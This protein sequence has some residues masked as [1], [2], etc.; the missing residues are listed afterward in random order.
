M[1]GLDKMQ[2][3]ELSKSS[4]GTLTISCSGLPEDCENLKSIQLGAFTFEL[5]SHANMNQVQHNLTFISKDSSYGYIKST[6]AA[7]Y[8]T[9]PQSLYDAY[10]KSIVPK[11][12]APDLGGG[13]AQ[14]RIRT[15]ID[16]WLNDVEGWTVGDIL[17][18]IYTGTIAVP[19]GLD[20]AVNEMQVNA[21]V[22]VVSVVRSL[23][24]SPGLQCSFNGINVHITFG[25]GGINSPGSDCWETGITKR[26]SEYK[27]TVIG[28][29][30]F[31]LNVSGGATI[32][33]A[34]S[35]D[36][37]SGVSTV[38]GGGA[39]GS[40][41]GVSNIGGG[42]DVQV[43]INKVGGLFGTHLEHTT[44]WSSTNFVEAMF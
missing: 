2:Y 18:N 40:G 12:L 26:E 8:K 39:G 19:G 25:G 23:I 43:F 32:A 33:D 6:E 34:S 11:E 22:P 5:I 38:F 7:V 15:C 37:F 9:I 24:P 14:V 21:G 30:S 3:A 13:G 29:N 17:N 35:T 41:G 10:M 44:S 1:G 20:Y 4:D 16:P 27:N 31:P 36:V 42:S 28:G